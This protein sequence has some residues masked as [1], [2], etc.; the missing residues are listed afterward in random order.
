MPSTKILEGIVIYEKRKLERREFWQKHVRLW[1][2]S[3]MTQADYCRTHGLK[4]HRLTYYKLQDDKHSSATAPSHGAKVSRAEKLF[5]PIKMPSPVGG[6][7]RVT[8]ENGVTMEFE[9]NS[10]PVW[11]GKIL[12]SIGR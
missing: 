7:I 3:G 6:S 11:I 9:N 5:L 4:N 10:D 8:L 1:R 12:G 2:A